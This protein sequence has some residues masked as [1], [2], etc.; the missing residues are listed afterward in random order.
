MT[1]KNDMLCAGMGISAFFVAFIISAP[2]VWSQESTTHKL[3]TIL[4]QPK[5]EVWDPVTCAYHTERNSNDLMSREL[6]NA[7]P[8]AEE[9]ADLKTQYPVR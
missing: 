2:A 7:G 1:D 4:S 9:W 3:Q 5:L 6:L 8:T